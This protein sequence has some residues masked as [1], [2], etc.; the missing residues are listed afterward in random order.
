MKLGRLIKMCLN[1]THSKIRIDKYLSDHFPIRNGLKQGDADLW[2]LFFN[3]VL[4]YAIRKVQKKQVGLK[5]NGRHQR[6]V[7]ADDITL[8]GDNIDTTKKNTENLIS[9]AKDVGLEVNADKT[10]CCPV[11]RMQGKIMTWR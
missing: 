7:Y 9:A 10:N 6:L 11:T 8:L 3:F 2:P 5:L 1:E 4:E